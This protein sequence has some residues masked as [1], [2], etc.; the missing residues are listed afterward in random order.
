MSISGYNTNLHHARISRLAEAGREFGI[1]PHDLREECAMQHSEA[2]NPM[3][4]YLVENLCKKRARK[5][6][7]FFVHDGDCGKGDEQ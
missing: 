6:R 2:A 4:W 1:T 3:E 7:G 5:F